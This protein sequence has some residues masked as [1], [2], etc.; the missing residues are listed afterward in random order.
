[1]AEKNQKNHQG[2]QEPQ[3]ILLETINSNYLTLMAMAVGISC[4]LNAQENLL[5]EILGKLNGSAASTSGSDEKSEQ[6][7]EEQQGSQSKDKNGDDNTGDGFNLLDHL[8]TTMG[9]P[10]TMNN[11]GETIAESDDKGETKISY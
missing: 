1:M 5:R 8:V 6:S 4:R 10:T 3:Q 2:A 9:S 11:E 7:D